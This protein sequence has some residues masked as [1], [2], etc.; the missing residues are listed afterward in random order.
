MSIA[1]LNSKLRT[2]SYL[3][4]GIEPTST[5]HNEFQ[6]IFG[7]NKQAIQWVA[8]MASYYAAERT[9]LAAKKPE[10]KSAATKKPAPKASS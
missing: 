6:A 3:D 8:R 2:Q 9:E 4:G 10:K 5:D 7:D 1:D